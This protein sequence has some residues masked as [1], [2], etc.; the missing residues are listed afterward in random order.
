MIPLFGAVFLG[1]AVEAL[2]GFGAT[3]VTL[4]IAS[5]AMPVDGILAAFLPVNL[6]LSAYLVIQYRR[7]IDVAYLV[8]RVLPYMLPGVA[9]G[10][11]WANAGGPD[12]VRTTFAA[13]VTTLAAIELY[14]QFRAKANRPL[15]AGAAAA[16]IAGSGVVHGMFACGGPLLVY[17]MGRE[18][19]DKT[20]LR[21]TL[22]AIWLTMNALVVATLAA[23]G[24]IGTAS[25]TTSG[26]LLLPLFAGATL[27]EWAHHRMPIDR[28][29]TVV[30]GLLFVAGGLLLLR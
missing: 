27:G 3:V 7:H 13:F 18:I 29:R 23:A 10:R 22:A 9:L 5:Q 19:T 11:W 26:L 21:A 20:R 24:Q 12:L 16:A 1:F 6:L 14:S 8:R 28:F 25:L 2:A 17:A 30:F 4:A 15:R